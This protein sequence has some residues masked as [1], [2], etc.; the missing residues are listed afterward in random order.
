MTLQH[1]H[2]YLGLSAALLFILL[3]VT[4]IL[5]NHTDGLK[6]GSQYVENT[7]L[8]NWY[9]IKKSLLNHAYAVKQ[10]DKIR[11]FSHVQK[12]VYLD[13]QPFPLKTNNLQA[14]IWLPSEIW[15][16]LA[17]ETVH[18]YTADGEKIDSITPL[19]GLPKNAEKLGLD[20]NKTL[21]LFAQQHSYQADANLLTWQRSTP[22][23]TLQW[24]QSSLPPKTLQ[25]TLENQ[26][27]D[28]ILDW[29]R[30]LLDLHSGRI[31]GNW[32]VYL[33]DTAA[34]VLL[35]LSGSGFLIWYR[36]RKLLQRRKK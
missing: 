19:Q 24:Q 1:W 27:R 20:A 34:I 8:L 33:V 21:W 23:P 5:L 13:D 18:I 4:G 2:R 6:L 16:I 14:V 10:D 29:E 3:L 26:S 9:G 15:V 11:W 25:Y 36:R 32:G 7:R 12:Q 17:D 35:I 30:V 31:V 28:G 22:P